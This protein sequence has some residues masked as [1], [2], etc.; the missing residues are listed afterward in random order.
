MT[1]TV[2]PPVTADTP[3]ESKD[4]IKAVI[5]A[6]EKLLDDENARG[7]RRPRVHNPRKL[8]SAAHVEVPAKDERKRRNKAQRQA[9]KA[10]R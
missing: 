4:A 1:A 8:G 7:P 2:H 10:G 9:R 3:Q 5:D 6:A